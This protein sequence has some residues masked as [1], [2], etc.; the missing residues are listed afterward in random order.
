VSGISGQN[1]F[2]AFKYRSE[3]NERAWWVDEVMI[4]GDFTGETTA[5]VWKTEYPKLDDI[6]ETQ[7]DVVV[8][9]DEAGM[10]YFKVQEDGDPAPSIEDVMDADSIEIMYGGQDYSTTVTGLTTGITYDVY[11]IARDA[12]GNVQSATVMVSGTT[13]QRTLDM[14]YPVGGETF[15][16]GDTVTMTWTS[17]NIDS[18]RIY[19]D[20]FEGEGWH[21]L[22]DDESKIGADLG[23]FDIPVP[24]S[25]GVDSVKLL[26]ADADDF[27]LNDSCG[28]FYLIDTIGPMIYMTVPEDSTGHVSI[29][30]ELLVWFN[31]DVSVGTGNIS[32]YEHDGSLVEAIDVTGDQVEIGEDDGYMV[33]IQASVRLAN[34]TLHYVLMDEGTFV[35]FKGNAFDGISYDTIW[36]FTTIPA[37]IYFSEYIE[38]NYGNNKALEIYNP[39]GSDVD[40]SDFQ[41]WRATNGEPWDEASDYQLGGILKADSVFVICHADAIEEIKARSDSIGGDLN[42][43]CYFNGDDAMG[44]F[45]EVE[46][47]WVLM[48]AIGK[49]TGIDP[50]DGWDVA[51]VTEATKDHTLIR[52]DFIVTGNP[53][54]ESSAGTGG[55]DSEWRVHEAMYYENLGLVSPPS[56]TV[57][58]IDSFYLA[59]QTGPGVLDSAAATIDV[60][61]I[62]GTDL[63]ALVPEI[64]ISEKAK[65]DPPSGEPADFSG[66]AVVFTVTAEDRTT[67]RDWSVTVTE[68]L[69]LSSEKK[70]LTFVLDDESKAAV[71]D[72]NAFTVTAEV[73]YGTALTALAPTITVSAGATISPASEVAQDFSSGAVTY[74]VTAQDESTQDWAVTVSEVT[75]VEVANLGAL[76]ASTADNTTLYKVTGEVVVTGFMDYRGRKYLQDAT[77]AIEIDDYV[78]QAVTTTYAIGDGITGLMGTL[79]NYYDWL[80]I[81]PIVDPGAPSSTGNTITP[82]KVSIDDFN[83]NFD[84]HEAQLIRID[85]IGFGATG[86]FGNGDEMNVGWQGDSTILK[87]NFFDTDLTGTAIPEYANVIGIAYWH[88][89]EAKI[90]PRFAADVIEIEIIPEN[91]EDISSADNIR[92]Y[93]NPGSGLFT[94]ELSSGKLSDLDVEVYSLNGKM[95]YRNAFRSVMEIHEQIDLRDAARGMYIM[96][97]RNADSVSIH[98]I[99]IQ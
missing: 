99:L 79:E 5:P 16:V 42:G 12:L 37:D 52:K 61:V 38:G 44:I 28:A 70:I 26:L 41:I 88:Y 31:E 93:P 96:R 30:P 97:V 95:V 71:I 51:G 27:A 66:G 2:F 69:T 56:S 39:T 58:E 29:I 47:N 98:K 32:I 3:D 14:T 11:F 4:K 43:T 78:L 85:T 75:P 82:K 48:D 1:V 77:G 17:E 81:H 90:V 20:A 91:V 49:A 84:D 40:L 19:V 73:K 55:Y 67:T 15:Y 89:G 23:Q 36:R 24:L 72:T 57:A 54:W 60:E 35:D 25:A 33:S 92:V 64:Y 80:E 76:R 34:E 18:L 74:T 6:Q 7:L 87:V 10:A 65:V 53:D 86:T 21:P 13:L 94:L 9:I 45:K 59:E 68:A 8:N 83:T 22:S 63:G 50:G 62:K 46:G